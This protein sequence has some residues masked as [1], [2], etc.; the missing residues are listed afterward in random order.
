MSDPL[1]AAAADL[2]RATYPADSVLIEEG[3]DP[4]R[5][6]VLVTGEVVV[7]RDG[8]PFARIDRP[9]AIFGEM[10]A[11]LRQPATATVRA[12]TDVVVHVADD[13]EA[14]LTERPG[15]ALAV[16]RVTAGRLDR[17]TQ[18]LVDVKAQFAEQE[19]HLGMVGSILDTLVHHQGAPARTGSARDPEGDHLH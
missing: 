15:A 6:L 4:G 17:M 7:E 12:A 2:P 1:L 18:Y 19:G 3:T 5:L 16:L 14:F 10:A 13:P 11:V 8:V 9:G